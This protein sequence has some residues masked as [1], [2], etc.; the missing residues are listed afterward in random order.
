MACTHLLNK[1]KT[2]SNTRHA[3]RACS[4]KLITGNLIENERYRR[5]AKS[6]GKN[7]MH[8]GLTCASEVRMDSG[9]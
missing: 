4:V 3:Q 5:E 1:M 9:Q 8:A 6:D 2:T 7:M